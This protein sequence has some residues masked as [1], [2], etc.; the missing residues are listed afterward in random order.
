[1]A[2]S[3]SENQTLVK[4]AIERLFAVGAHYAY[5][6]SRRH[7]SVRRFIFGA[8]S[9]VE[10][11]DLEKTQALLE[12]AKTFV[13]SLGV[14]GKTLLIVGGKNEARGAVTAAAERLAQP[15]VA[16]RW[17]GGTLSNFKQVRTRVE[18][19]IGLRDARERG[20]LSKYTKLERLLIDRD[21]ER[22]EHRFGGLV[23]L[24][25]LPAAVFVIDPRHEAIAVREARALD[26]PVVA[27]ANSDCDIASIEYPILGND[28]NM[29]SITFFVEEIA[30]SFSEGQR[31]RK[32]ETVSSASAVDAEAQ[33]AA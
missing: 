23:S 28:A 22:L 6:R 18:K 11:F 26:I 2:K 25:H 33:V 5:T 4:D 31:I 24:A 3:A 7:P 30:A 16:G 12:K 1:M 17:I 29:K 8:K 10:I 32:E 20:E 15:F 21:I 14:S 19:L 9:T 27:I 13:H